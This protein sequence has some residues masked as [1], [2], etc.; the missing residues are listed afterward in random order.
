MYGGGGHRRREDRSVAW[1]GDHR[2][3]LTDGGGIGDL[4]VYGGGWGNAWER[5]QFGT[6]TT[7]FFVGRSEPHLAAPG[8]AV[9]VRN[10]LKERI[11]QPAC[12]EAI[13]FV[14]MLQVTQHTLFAAYRAENLEYPTL[15][16]R[17]EASGR[18]VRGPRGYGVGG[19]YCEVWVRWLD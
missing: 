6:L 1:E 11:R 18:R 9:K 19:R 17:K 10:L 14:P 7:N 2:V 8:T 13:A 3:H 16:P 15:A 4:G 5:T 12:A